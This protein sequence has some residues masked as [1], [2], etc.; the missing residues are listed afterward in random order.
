MEAW[1]VGW[2][3]RGILGNEVG[4]RG[5][6]VLGGGEKVFPGKLMVLECTHF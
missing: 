4:V 6:M 5:G 3:H 2:R 1:I